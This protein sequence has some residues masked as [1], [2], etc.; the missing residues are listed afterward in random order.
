MLYYRNIIDSNKW[1]PTDSKK[2]SKDDP[3]LLKAST[4]AI[5]YPINNIV[6]NV[7]FLNPPQWE[8]R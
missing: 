2:N 6:E 3:L 7:S 4:V 8:R 1:E 5:E